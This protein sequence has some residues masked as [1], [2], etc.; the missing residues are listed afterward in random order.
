MK[1]LKVEEPVVINPTL[2]GIITQKMCI[3]ANIKSIYNRDVMVLFNIHR[4][5]AFVNDR[6]IFLEALEESLNL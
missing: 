1:A 3:A 6:N 5:F 2:M 4:S